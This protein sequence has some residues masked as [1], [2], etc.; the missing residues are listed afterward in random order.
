MDENLPD[1]YDSLLWIMFPL[2]PQTNQRDFCCLHSP[3]RCAVS[4]GRL[5]Q[6][7]LTKQTTNIS[8]QIR[9]LQTSDRAT[10]EGEVMEVRRERQQRDGADER[11]STLLSMTEMSGMSAMLFLPQTPALV[12][13]YSLLLSP[14]SS[15]SHLH[16]HLCSIFSPKCLR[17]WQTDN[18]VP[19]SG[20]CNF[21]FLLYLK[22]SS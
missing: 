10:G 1:V 2:S 6:L 15:A 21:S 13:P 19:S 5:C 9:H 22:K 16:T 11:V 18:H 3:P 4:W 17:S 14:P 12:H 20:A 7:Q 8:P